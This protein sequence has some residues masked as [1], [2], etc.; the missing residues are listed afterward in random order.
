MELI[1]RIRRPALGALLAAAATVLVATVAAA[2]DPSAEST[3]GLT[4]HGVEETMR[5]YCVIQDG[6]LWLVLPDGTR[7]ELVT[8]TSDPVIANAG[9]GSFHP[10]EEATMRTA[11]AAL[12]APLARLRADVFILPYPRRSGLESAAR[13]GLILLSPGVRPLTA[14]HQHAEF[15]HELGHLVHYSRMPDAAVAEWTRYRQVRGITNEAVYNASATHANRPHEIFAEDFRALVGGAL[16]NYSGTIENAG[17]AAPAS[18]AGLEELMRA[19][20]GASGPASM[21][22]LACYPNPS[23]EMVS[24]ARSGGEPEALEVYDL[25]GRRVVTLLPTGESLVTWRWDG[26]DTAGSRV[27][28]GVYFARARARATILRLTRLR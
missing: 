24:F 19:I 10:F 16:A 27:G 26:R 13:P 2:S 1:A 17:L 25:G 20:A 14:E 9:D 15:I 18:V 7:H 5:D 8:S 3:V 23:S 22:P 21:L 12:R 11:L 28:A 6:A 4:I